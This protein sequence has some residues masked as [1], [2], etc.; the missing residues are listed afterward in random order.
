MPFVGFL[1]ATFQ[2]FKNQE[3]NVLELTYYSNITEMIE[4]VRDFA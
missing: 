2:Y 3:E 4:K 1:I